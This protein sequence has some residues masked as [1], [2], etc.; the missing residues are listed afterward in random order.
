MRRLLERIAGRSLD[1]RLATIAGGIRRAPTRLAVAAMRASAT[2]RI[3]ARFGA[4]EFNPLDPAFSADPYPTFRRLRERDPVHK[5]AFGPWL[6]TRYDDAIAVAN[7]ERFLHPDYRADVRR[8]TAPG[9]MHLTRSDMVISLNPPDHT[10]LRR[11]LG[12][13]FAAHLGPAL[14]PRIEAL[15]HG[16]IDRVGQARCMDAAAAFA[17]PLPV[18]VIGEIFGLSREESVRCAA[19]TR[20]GTDALGFA[21]TAGRVARAHEANGKLREYFAELIRIRRAEPGPD[22][23]SALVQ[24]QAREADFSDAEIV[25]N[26]ILFFGAGYETTVAFIGTA[27]RTLMQHRDAWERLA[28][29]PD[30]VGRSVDELLRYDAPLQFFG[31]QAR[32]DMRLAGK[33]IRRGETVL[34]LTGAVNRDPARFPDPDRLDLGRRDSP[35]ATFGYGIHACIG[36]S[37]ARLEGQI[38][39]EVLLQRLPTLRP[40]AG[41]ARWR[42]DSLFRALDVLPVAWD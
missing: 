5:S 22:F 15:A 24:A 38:A 31:R 26:C 7:D 23:V 16:L 34:V 1:D 41:P 4:F 19:W 33:R 28:A 21:P 11:I 32:E 9:P 13:A 18:T 14:R 36:R 35:S 30:L 6:V 25:A 17:F 8:Q 3:L 37:L 10:R 27:L 2:R 29:D 40:G 12:E 39:L 42:H 20:V